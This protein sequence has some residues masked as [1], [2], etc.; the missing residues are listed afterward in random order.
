MIYLGMLFCLG[1]IIYGGCVFYKI[2]YSKHIC[3]QFNQSKKIEKSYQ[4]HSFGGIVQPPEIIDVFPYVNGFVEQVFVRYGQMVEAGERLLQIGQRPYI[5]AKETSYAHLQSAKQHLKAVQAYY[6]R[7]DNKKDEELPLNE[8]QKVEEACVLAQKRVNVAL[9]KYEQAFKNYTYTNL[10][11]PVKGLIIQMNVSLKN[12]V[13]PAGK[14]L[15]RIVNKS[16]VL[17]KC[18]IPDILYKELMNKTQN[19]MTVQL[20]MSENPPCIYTGVFKSAE[21]NPN[22]SKSELT[23]YFEFPNP[24]DKLREGDKLNIRLI[25]EVLQKAPLVLPKKNMFLAF[26]PTITSFCFKGNFLFDK[27]YRSDKQCLRGRG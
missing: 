14:A 17:V 24:D 13:S 25:Q 3:L 21:S 26:Y 5:V 23:V 7:L 16:S 10:K 8:R 1:L 18:H 22:S 20:V 15:F 4:I 27:K 11:A 9:A 2:R 12:Y 6:Q 19:L